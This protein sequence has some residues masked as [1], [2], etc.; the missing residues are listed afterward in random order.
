MMEIDPFVADIGR[1]APALLCMMDARGNVEYVNE[2]WTALVGATPAEL[3]GR[4]WMTFVHP[5]DIGGLV[6]DFGLAL[7]AG[8]AYRGEFRMRHAD[9]AYRWIVVRAEPERDAR[10][11]IVR[12]F[13]AGND[14]D[15]H[16]RAMDALQ[17]LA[18][19]GAT[20]N[21]ANDVDALLEGVAR[22]ALA[23]LADIA[24]F[25]LIGP[26]GWSRRVGAGAAGVPP[27]AVEM[28]LTFPTKFD[29]PHPISRAMSEAKPLHLATIDEAYI[30]S[31]IADPARRAAWRAINIRSMIVAPMM[32]GGRRLGALTMLRTHSDRAF[33]ASD[34]R[35]V[36][37]VARR[38]AVAVENIRLTEAA[39]RESSER[40][41]RFRVIADSMPMLMW[42]ASPDGATEWHNLRWHEYTGKS[43]DSPME[44]GWRTLHP[45]DV[46]PTRAAWL[47]ATDTGENLELEHRI[48]RADGTYRW[49]LTRATPER[50]ANGA[51]V[52]WYGTSTDVHEARRARRTLQ[53][54]SELGP[55][56][57]ASLEVQATLDAVMHVVVPEFADWAIINLADENGDLRVAA[58]YHR[59][60][61]KRAELATQLGK[62]YA[63][64]DVATGAPEATRSG[65]SILYEDASR[66]DAAKIVTPDVLDAF[67]S[68]G[69][70]SVLVAPLVVGGGARGTLNVAMYDSFR[71]F[72]D[73]DV[74][75]FQELARRI[76]PAIANAELFERERLVARSFQDAALPAT[77]ADIPACTFSA[78]YEAGS[79]EALVGGDWYDAFALADGR[80]V[81]SIGDVAGS[82]LQAAVTMANMRQAI[83]GVAYVHP[84]PALM[85]EAADLALRSESPNVF[86]TAFVAVIDPVEDMISFT[87]AGHPPPLLYTPAGD[88]VP[89]EAH[90]LPLGLREHDGT[91]STARPIE[92]GSVLV[93]FTDGLIES[94]H[95]IDEGYRRL[96]AALR[97]PAT[98]RARDLAARLRDAVLVE[99]ARDDVA[100]L[101]GR[102]A[103]VTFE[104]HRVDVRNAA[105]SARFAALL[106]AALEG[107]GYAPDAIVNAEIVLA[108]LVG[109]LVRHTPGPATFVI[110]AQPGHVVLHALDDGP[111]YRFLSRLPTDTLSERGRGLFLISALAEAFHVTPRAFGGSHA[112]VT[113]STVSA[114]DGQRTRWSQK[115]AHPLPAG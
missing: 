74:E 72:R 37:E 12:W 101:C 5:D 93:L 11:E 52:R 15:A 113:F 35:V 86:V 6:D 49:F 53:V 96:E 58:I 2:R 18:E 45:E 54:F 20:A 14:I 55:A 68:V 9:G 65:M 66:E 51:I 102:Y 7:A 106:I 40:D 64:A 108:E 104:R 81:L 42:T 38:A 59:D 112:C 80:I 21:S 43:E 3:L 91:P 19:S 24:F 10:G 47:T 78:I 33:E 63:T 82:G 28:T 89:L 27:E 57:S 99:G 100:I 94:T 95:D 44:I 8:D 114:D 77:L 23:G 73:V 29:E 50:D 103:G 98:L 34:V 111:G 83:R 30:M 48:R 105:E 4:G 39:R 79:A 62:I 90:G 76:A 32:V 46:A 84:D 92:P 85:L 60:E 97:D 22:A 31:S 110:D 16:R 56:L 107:A 75:F 41:Q 25:D 1:R 36:E 88:I 115:S 17:L 67:W 70:S 13:G 69:F 71:R 61:G 87:T 26:D 109:N